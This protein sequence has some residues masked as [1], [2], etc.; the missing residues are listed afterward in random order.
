[1]LHGGPHVVLEQLLDLAARGLIGRPRLR[2]VHGCD[3][4]LVHHLGVIVRFMGFLTPTTVLL[5]VGLSGAWPYEPA[6]VQPSNAR[7]WLYCVLGLTHCA[8]NFMM[9]SCRLVL[10]IDHL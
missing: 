10:V 7:S 8:L 9:V 4:H 6:L 2:L 3:T 5:P 1:M